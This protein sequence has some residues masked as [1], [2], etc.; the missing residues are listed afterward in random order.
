MERVRE[1][2]ERLEIA[3][4]EEDNRGEEE[5]GVGDGI[6]R[7]LCVMSSGREIETKHGE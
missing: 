2:G 4:E 7:G 3:R 5:V 6:G 1:V